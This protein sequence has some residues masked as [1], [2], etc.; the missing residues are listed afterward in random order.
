MLTGIALPVSL[1]HDTGTDA[2]A[3]KFAH[4]C[5]TPTV[6]NA[7]HCGRQAFHKIQ[8]PML[9]LTKDVRYGLRRPRVL[10]AARYR[11]PFVFATSIGPRP[12][13]TSTPDRADIG[14]FARRRTE[15]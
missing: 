13:G 2:R 10:S 8:R 3:V 4:A 11:L 6:E 9:Y 7:L 1:G 12:D 15:I 14:Q 5:R